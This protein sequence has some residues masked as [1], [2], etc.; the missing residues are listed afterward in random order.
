MST[1]CTASSATGS[2][3]QRMRSATT[4]QP[5]LGPLPSR[6]TVPSMMASTG[7]TTALMSGIA[8]SSQRWY[9][10]RIFSR[11]PHWFLSAPEMPVLAWVFITRKGDEQPLAQD[12]RK[13]DRT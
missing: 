1:A 3:E 8:S 11:Q 7:R 5:D 10:W 4:G 9:S 12:P 6:A 2:R 13:A